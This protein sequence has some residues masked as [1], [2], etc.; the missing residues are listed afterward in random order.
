MRTCGFVVL[1]GL[2]AALAPAA[3]EPPPLLKPA[4]PGEGLVRFRLPVTPG[5]P[6][7]MSFAAQ[8]PNGKKKGDPI[9]VQVA[10]DTIPDKSYVSAKT[11]QSW[12]YDVPK[13]KEF[14][15]PALT[16]TAAQIAPPPKKGRD[17]VVRLP[18]IKL[19]VVE[20]TASKDGTVRMCDLSVSALSLY[21]GHERTTEPR[22]SFA[23]KFLELNVLEAAVKRPGTD[24]APLPEITA[25]DPKLVPA[26]APQT[27]RNGLNVFE[28]AAVNGQTSYKTADG[29]TNPVNV[30]VGSIMN[31]PD[32]VV[33]SLGLARGCKVEMDQ[34]AVGLDAVGVE[35]KSEFIPGKVKELRLAVRTGPGLKAVKDLVLKDLPV[36]VDRSQ[37]EG[38]MVVGQG[39]TDKHFADAVYAGGADGWKLHGRLD[40]ALLLDIKTRPKQKP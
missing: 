33:L 13:N 12:G 25:A 3:D 18:N 29:K 31:V 19:T 28:Y 23:D 16:F 40:P 5:V 26:Y 6:K 30:L 14:V 32:G 39:F 8:V 27:V 34:A 17:L 22:V 37:S 24:D 7:T 15:L 9:D 20:S 4:A 2:G 21:L 36:L 1:F 11:L 35:A 10:F 38:Y